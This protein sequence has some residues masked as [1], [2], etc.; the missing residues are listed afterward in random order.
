VVVHMLLSGQKRQK[1]VRVY[2]SPSITS[3]E[4]AAYQYLKIMLLSRLFD[5]LEFLVGR[6]RPSVIED[7]EHDFSL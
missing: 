2:L 3:C 7:R 6:D 5:Q 4:F 1:K